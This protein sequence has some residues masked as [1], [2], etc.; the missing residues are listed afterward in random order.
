MKLE[1]DKQCSDISRACYLSWDG[2]SYYNYDAPTIGK[3]FLT[4]FL[5]KPL[6]VNESKTISIPKIE[7]LN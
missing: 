4:D 3:E 5:P 6:A 2:N 1:I 7:Y